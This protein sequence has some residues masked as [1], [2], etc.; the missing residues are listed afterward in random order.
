MDRNAKKAILKNR[1]KLLNLDYFDLTAPLLAS[2]IF[3]SKKHKD[4]KTSALDSKARVDL[5]LEWLEE[6]APKEA[7]PI[8]LQGVRNCKELI[9]AKKIKREASG[10]VLASGSAGTSATSIPLDKLLA[11]IV[12]GLPSSIGKPPTD[13]PKKPK[14]AKLKLPKIIPPTT[15]GVPPPPPI[16]GLPSTSL[17]PPPVPKAKKR[18]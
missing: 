3:T 12:P 8:F 17:P 13:K 6:S 9:L 14:A 15:T 11:E 18:K 10:T 4:I 7:F 16:N 1:V 2:E 5:L